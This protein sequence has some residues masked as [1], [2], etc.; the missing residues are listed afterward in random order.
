MTPL[1]L[2]AGACVFCV[3][4]SIATAAWWLYAVA[5]RQ[6]WLGLAYGLAGVVYATAWGTGVVLIDRSLRRLHAWRTRPQA[7]VI[8]QGIKIAERTFSF[9]PEI[10]DAR[11]RAVHALVHMGASK[12]DAARRID[13]AL[14]ALPG[15]AKTSVASLVQA[16]L[17]A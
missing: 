14:M 1:R 7:A 16:G 15:T 10:A 8:P 3:L 13:A 12:T 17:Q 11:A 9:N 5:V 4:A 6:D 2:L